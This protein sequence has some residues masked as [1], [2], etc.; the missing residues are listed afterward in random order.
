MLKGKTVI[1]L[2]DVNTGEMEKVEKENMVTNALTELFRPLGLIKSPNLILNTYAPYYQKLLGGIL[3]FDRAI[4]ENPDNV[5]PPADACLVGCG[6]YGL[7]NNTVGKKRGGYNQVESELSLNNRYMKF[8]YD[9][10]TSQANGTI[11]C[12]CLTN[13]NGGLTSY[14]S[15]DAVQSS[16]GFMIPVSSYELKYVGAD[17][18]GENTA[19]KMSSIKIGISEQLFLIDRENDTAYYFRIN[20]ETSIS[21]I[22]RRAYLKSISILENPKTQKALIDEFRL[23]ELRTELKTTYISYNFDHA[24]KSLYIISSASALK[25]GN[26]FQVTRISLEDWKVTQYEMANTTDATLKTSDYAAYADGGY[27]YIKGNT[28]PYDVYKF[29]IGNAANVT[30]IKKHGAE[31]DNGTPKMSVNGR[32]YYEY[33]SSNSSLNRMY[34]LDTVNNTFLATEMDRIRGN[35]LVGSTASYVPVLNEP[36]LYYLSYGRADGSCFVMPCNYL[37]T[38]NNLATPV[39]KTADKTMKIIYTIQEV[40]EEAQA[41]T[42]G[43]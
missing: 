37:A 22:R 17:V 6:C 3:L 14:G 4:E 25:A 19:D 38:I 28:N 39:T 24:D 5:F 10:T 7:Q 18:A 13:V 41:N 42:G 43:E 27:V 34:I 9:F 32:V 40:A 30:K 35:N 33:Y 23:S 8:V 12:I 20:N 29:E 11:G 21:I 26:L 15:D 36:M 2:T 16:G 31:E 1:E